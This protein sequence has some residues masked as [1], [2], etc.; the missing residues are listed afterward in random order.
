MET[1]SRKIIQS[2]LVAFLIFKP[3]RFQTI[4]VL[5]GRID[6]IYIRSCRVIW[7]PEI[8]DVTG[9]SYIVIIKGHHAWILCNQHSHT[10]GTLSGFSRSFNTVFGNITCNDQDLGLRRIFHMQFGIMEGSSRPIAGFF[11]L[12]TTSKG[13]DAQQAMHKD[14]RSLT[15]VNS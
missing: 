8:H 10:S 15:L 7:S 12:E 2:K 4:Q 13:L 1:N 5:L 9:L 14:G 6:T 3:S 11:N